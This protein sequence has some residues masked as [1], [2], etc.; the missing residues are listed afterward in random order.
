MLKTAII[1][2]IDEGYRLYSRKKDPSGKR[3]NLGTFKT[4]EEAKKREKQVQ[5]F[6]SQNVDDKSNE[7]TQMLSD[8]SEISEYLEDA[9]FIDEAKKISKIMYLVDGSLI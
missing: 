5:F 9:G 7:E 1:R 8:L 3:R 4:R 6:K 2:K